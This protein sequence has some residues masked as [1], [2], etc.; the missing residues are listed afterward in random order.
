[1]GSGSI[2]GASFEHEKKNKE[3]HINTNI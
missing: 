3:K 2:L 1:M